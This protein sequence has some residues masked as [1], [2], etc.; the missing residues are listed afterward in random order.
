MTTT[1]LTAMTGLEL[2]RWMQT[3]RPTDIPSIGRLLGM[4]FDEVD[5]GRIVI[6][7][8]TR[9]DFANPLGTV[10]GGIAATLLD[11]VMGCAVHTT[12]PAGAGYT[13]LELKV[14][15][16]RAARTDGQILTAEGNVIHAGRR[17]ATAEGK[18]LDDQGKLIAHATTTCMIL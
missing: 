2:M 13:T 9:P 6:S 8:D 18:V 10:H 3:E 11:S 16:I 4:R 5:H 17:T 14:N 15:Y 1:D 7:L 12:L